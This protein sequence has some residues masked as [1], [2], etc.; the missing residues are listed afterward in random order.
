MSLRL[1]LIALPV[2]LVG[3]VLTR[4]S[5]AGEAG[6]EPDYDWASI[7]PQFGAN[8]YDF[9]YPD[10]QATDFEDPWAGLNFGDSAPLTFAPSSSDFIAP[11]GFGED[12]TGET[13]YGRSYVMPDA[14]GFGDEPNYFGADNFDPNAE[15]QAVMDAPLIE[16][17]SN[18]EKIRGLLAAERGPVANVE[19]FEPFVIEASG[20]YG[21][22]PEIIRAVIFHESRYKPDA[23]APNSS[24]TGLM[25]MLKGTA[26]DYGLKDTIFMKGYTRAA[27]LLDPRTAI[28]AGTKMLAQMIA[29]FGEIDGV[30]AYY[31]GPGNIKKEKQYG[32]SS[33]VLAEATRYAEDIF[34]NV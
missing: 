24:A 22:R 15:A 26:S 23:M 1:A 34:A 21:V 3:I 2:F 20:T 18:Y 5:W 16:G 8:G 33:P 17:G 25:Q 13:L 11:I 9:G 14:L 28:D 4:R 30:R 31:A 12:T 10:F 27:A 29:Q 19:K 7:D 32:T 6:M